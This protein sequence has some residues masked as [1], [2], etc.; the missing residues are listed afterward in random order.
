MSFIIYVDF[1]KFFKLAHYR[2]LLTIRSQGSLPSSSIIVRNE[3]SFTRRD[4][5]LRFRTMTTKRETRQTKKNKQTNEKQFSQLLVLAAV[6]ILSRAK[7]CG[8][9]VQESPSF[10]VQRVGAEGGGGKKR[11]RKKKELRNYGRNCV[12]GWTAV[13][14]G[15]TRW[16]AFSGRHTQ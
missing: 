1:S 3:F 8:D 13:L 5:S 7:P 10:R 15:M 4:R 9:N 2:E 11:R 6:T 16:F 14:W 12:L